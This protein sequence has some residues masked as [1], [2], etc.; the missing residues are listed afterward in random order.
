MRASAAFPMIEPSACV[1]T[2][3]PLQ[4]SFL[5]SGQS[6]ISGLSLGPTGCAPAFNPAQ[7]RL[8][9]SGCSSESCSR[10]DEK[11]D[12]LPLR[13]ETDEHY[14]FSTPFHFPASESRELLQ[15]W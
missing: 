8:R 14:L 13:R 11:V 7:I 6:Q 15:A 2:Q 4:K 3:D 1:R 10:H 5:A 12:D 9:H